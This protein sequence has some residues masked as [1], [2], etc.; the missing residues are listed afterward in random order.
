MLERFRLNYRLVVEDGRL[1]TQ[2]GRAPARF[3]AAV[4]D[5]VRLHDIDAGAIE[6][7]GRGRNARLRFTDGFPER[8]RQAI[9][10][11]WQPPRGPG[12][13]GGRRAAG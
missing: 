12:S 3:F 2:T 13:G 5:I 7:K 8:G 1:T 9:R 10:N 4:A 6:C 11:V